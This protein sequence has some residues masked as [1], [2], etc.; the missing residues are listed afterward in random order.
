MHTKILLE[1]YIDNFTIFFETVRHN[2]NCTLGTIWLSFNSSVV[3]TLHA[4]M[5]R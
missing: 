5:H 3:L 2:A 4:C 1:T